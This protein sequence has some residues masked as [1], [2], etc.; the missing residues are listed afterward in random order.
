MNGRSHWSTTSGR[1]SNDSLIRLSGRSRLAEAI[2]YNLK[3]WDGLVLFLDDGRLEIDTNTV[4]RAIRPIA[5]NRKNALFAGSDRGGEHWAVVAS[6][7]ETCK[8]N[9]VNPH[10]YLSDALKRLV[11]GHPQSRIDD[12]MPWAYAAQ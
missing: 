2:R 11:E 8:F 9:D 6:L 1:G 4:E 3:L 12:L 10:A 5:L 7:I